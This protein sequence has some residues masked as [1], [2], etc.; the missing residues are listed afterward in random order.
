[1]QYKDERQLWYHQTLLTGTFA[2]HDRLKSFI[3]GASHGQILFHIKG[4]INESV[5]ELDVN[6]ISAYAITKIIVIPG[7]PKILDCNVVNGGVS[8]NR[9]TEV[10][11]EIIGERENSRT[12]Y[13]IEIKVISI[14]KHWRRFKF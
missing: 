8:E 3:K 4:N 5:R 7:K 12:A 13:I 9:R 10:N 11:R 2:Y 1:M 14:K 6:S